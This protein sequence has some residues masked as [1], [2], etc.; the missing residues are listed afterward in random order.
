MTVRHRRYRQY[1]LLHLLYPVLPGSLRNRYLVRQRPS[2][3]LQSHHRRYRQPLVH[4]FRLRHWHLRYRR[5]HRLLLHFHNHLF[6]RHRHRRQL[7]YGRLLLHQGILHHWR[8]RR[9]RHWPNHQIHRRYNRLLVWLLI[10]L[11]IY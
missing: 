6:R 10:R 11:Q 5:Y 9:H 4:W 3:S 7:R 8:H 1:L 2:L